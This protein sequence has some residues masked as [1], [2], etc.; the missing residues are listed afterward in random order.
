MPADPR[1]RQKSLEKKAA[2]RKE[3]KHQIVREETRPVGAQLALAVQFPVLHSWVSESCWENGIGW[4]LF[5]REFPDGRVAAALFLVDN[6]CLGVKNVIL[7]VT[8]RS[9]YNIQVVQKMRSQGPV[10]EF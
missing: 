4:A 8:N 6:Y 10:R 1:T 9:T 7:T 5:S 3:K 2:R